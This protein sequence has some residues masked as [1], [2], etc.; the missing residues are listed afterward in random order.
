[1]SEGIRLVPRPAGPLIIHAIT[2][3]VFAVSLLCGT[4]TVVLT[5]ARLEGR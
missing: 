4:V 2:R 5:T 1:M 3:G